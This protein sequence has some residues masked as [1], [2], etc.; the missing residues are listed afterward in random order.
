MTPCSK[1]RK[2]SV[3]WGEAIM[4]QE[5]GRLLEQNFYVNCGKCLGDK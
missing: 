2:G 3:S 4:V 5:T 1:R